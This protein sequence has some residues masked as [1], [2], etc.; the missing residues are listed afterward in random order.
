MDSDEWKSRVVRTTSP[1][2]PKCESTKLTMG[3]CTVGAK[4]VH[5]EL[6]C[7]KCTHE[8][9]ALFVLVG[10]YDGLPDM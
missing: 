2:C 1:L 6:V 4:T 5:Q 8:F 7:E 9:T 10:Y 3:A